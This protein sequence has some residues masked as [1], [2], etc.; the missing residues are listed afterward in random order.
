MR[1]AIG[2]G[3]HCLDPLQA[4]A[5]QRLHV[6]R[7]RIVP[8]QSFHFKLS[9]ASR[10]S[11]SMYYAQ[12]IGYIVLLEKYF[13]CRI[14][15]YSE[16]DLPSFY[17]PENSSWTAFVEQYPPF[18]TVSVPAFLA[19]RFGRQQ[20]AV[21]VPNWWHRQWRAYG[22]GN[23]ATT[24]SQRRLYQALVLL[25]LVAALFAVFVA[26]RWFAFGGRQDFVLV[27][28]DTWAHMLGSGRVYEDGHKE[29]ND[30][31]DHYRGAV[32]LMLSLWGLL[33]CLT[34]TSLLLDA[35]TNRVWMPV[36]QHFNDVF[37]YPNLTIVYEDLLAVMLLK[38][39]VN[40]K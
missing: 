31:R 11:D 35:S 16:I 30:I 40:D 39:V 8:L 7:N 1:P 2:A 34:M 33:N 6:I 9:M 19:P 10:G 26:V 29:N 32:V 37:M 24:M 27:V 14:T 36:F 18:D 13:R 21:I 12:W 3:D 38:K 4:T 22:H 20:Y 28:L 17:K 23:R 25:G 5:V 15:T